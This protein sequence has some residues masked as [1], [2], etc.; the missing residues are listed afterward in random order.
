MQ[1]STVDQ[2]MIKEDK[3]YF[4]DAFGTSI[5][6]PNLTSLYTLYQQTD[7][8]VVKANILPIL[9]EDLGTLLVVEIMIDA[10]HEV[11]INRLK[12]G[13]ISKNMKHVHDYYIIPKSHFALAQKQ[14][15]EEKAASLEENAHFSDCHFSM[16]PFGLAIIKTA[17][18]SYVNPYT[19]TS[20]LTHLI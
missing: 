10:T 20:C 19:S 18:P 5:F 16:F 15:L 4:V 8:E 11:T 1:T 13:E 9:K 2:L 12:T 6:L 7:D 14:Y 3:L 17:F